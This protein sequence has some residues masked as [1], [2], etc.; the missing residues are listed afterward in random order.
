MI[1]LRSVWVLCL[2]SGCAA[3]MAQEAGQGR[4]RR[5]QGWQ[6]WRRRHGHSGSCGGER[7]VLATDHQSAASAQRLDAE[8]RLSESDGTFLEPSS[9]PR[10][11]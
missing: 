4:S 7:V 2:A 1:G 11:V 9:T 5:E 8:G 6:Q 3:E 10:V